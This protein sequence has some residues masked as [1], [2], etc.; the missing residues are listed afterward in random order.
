[1]SQDADLASSKAVNADTQTPSSAPESKTVAAPQLVKTAT[2]SLEVDNLEARLKQATDLVKQANGDVL[3]LEDRAAQQQDSPHTA[4]LQMRVPQA[5]LDNTVSQI[6]TL[7]TVTFQ[8]LTAEDVSAQLVDFAARLRNL[9]KTE[10]TT[11]K[12]LDRSGKISEVL[13]VTQEL[14]RIRES[15]EKLVQRRSS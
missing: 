4:Y 1:V 3:K 12:I 11:L 7:G 13:A 9:R 15:I 14:S 8:S 10:E 5:Q 2:L 6:A